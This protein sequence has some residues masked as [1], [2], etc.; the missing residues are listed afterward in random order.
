MLPQLLQYHH[1]VRLRWREFNTTLQHPH[2]FS[3]FLLNLSG[4]MLTCQHQM[5][6]SDC[7]FPF[8]VFFCYRKHILYQKCALP[9][10]VQFDDME[11]VARFPGFFFFLHNPSVFA[12]AAR[13]WYHP[14]YPGTCIFKTVIMRSIFSLITFEIRVWHIFK[15]F[16]LDN[17]KACFL[18]LPVLIT[19][20]S[21]ALRR[22]T[23]LSTQPFIYR[24]SVSGKLSTR[25]FIY[26]ISVSGK[27][28]L[29]LHTS[30]NKAESQ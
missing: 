29:Y 23:I 11:N 15:K 10:V 5:I 9:A 22:R 14:V 8:Y 4:S 26:H 19:E 12:N 2:N 18:H 24:I 27:L 13:Q 1:N 25:P 28:S 30:K 7:I 6:S 16:I 21:L 20:K 17:I 3:R